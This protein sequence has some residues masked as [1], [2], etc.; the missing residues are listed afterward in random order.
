MSEFFI[1]P[2]DMSDYEEETDMNTAITL[3]KEKIPKVEITNQA[4]NILNETKTIVK[5]RTISKN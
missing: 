5:I 3:T 2:E 4:N 1:Y